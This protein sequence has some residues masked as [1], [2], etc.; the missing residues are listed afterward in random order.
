VQAQ[1]YP[2][3]TTKNQWEHIKDAFVAQQFG[4]PREV[5][6]QAVVNAILYVTMTGCQWRYLP[7]EYPPWQ[8]VYYYFRK[9]QQ[10]GTWHRIHERLRGQVRQKAGRHKHPTAGCLDSQSVKTTCVPG[11]RGYDAAKKVMGRKRHMLVDTMGLLL[12]V[13]VTTACVSES[14][15]ARLVLRRMPGGCKKLRKV[16]VDGGYFGTLLEWALVRLRLVL[17]VVKRDAQQKGFA[18]LPRRWVIERTFAWLSFH[19]RLSKDYER[20][21]KTSETFI[22]IA[23]TRLMLRRLHP[24]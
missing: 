15:G 20:F 2:S 21:P 11:E 24:N 10:D 14:A 3:D 17:E 19:R 1:I 5:D 8:N 13:V 4:R 12:C 6:L 22:Y 9:W 18:I 23:M 16:W 7:K